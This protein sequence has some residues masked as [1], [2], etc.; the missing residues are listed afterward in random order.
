MRGL[1]GE[2]RKTRAENTGRE[3]VEGVGFRRPES[4][5]GTQSVHPRTGGLE[6]ACA[7]RTVGP[8]RRPGSGLLGHWG[9]LPS[10]LTNVVMETCSPDQQ[11]AA[12]LRQ[13]PHWSFSLLLHLARAPSAGWWRFT[14]VTVG[15]RPPELLEV[16]GQSRIPRQSRN[17][18]LVPGLDPRLPPAETW[19][20]LSWPS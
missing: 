7:S 20:L 13:V 11:G 15:S 16:R 14:H 18:C 10:Q 9:R 3:Q 8:P 6:Q 4:L 2:G 1:S 5:A 19:T 17:S 12:T